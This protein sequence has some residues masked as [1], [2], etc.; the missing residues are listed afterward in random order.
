MSHLLSRRK[1][2]QL[3]GC[4][5]LSVVAQPLYPLF[6]SDTI[7]HKRSIPSSGEQLPI[8]GLGTWIQFDAGKSASERQPLSEVLNHMADKGGKVIDSSPMYGRSEEVIG[9]LTTQLAPA[10]AFF[11]ATKVWTTGRQEGIDQMEASM[12]KMRRNKMDL[13]QVHNLVDWKTHLQTLH[14]WKEEGK[15]RYIGITHYTDAAHNQLEQ[16][17]ATEDLDFVQFN[18]SIRNRNA[19]QRLPRAANDT[20]TAVIINQPFESGHLFQMV[21]GKA[22]PAW[23]IEYGIKSWAQFFLKYIISHPAVTC[24][25][26]GT[27]D[28]DHLVENMEAAHGWLPDDKMRKRMINYFD[29]L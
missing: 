18:Y 13:I 6:S 20:G 21:S 12:R 1:V 26:P 19:E 22:L 10:D 9:D 11:Y 7:M 14:K 5:G 25:I 23:S 28:P 16:L 2:L 24:A 17:I 4:S 8:V 27:S 15:V 29:S 3:M